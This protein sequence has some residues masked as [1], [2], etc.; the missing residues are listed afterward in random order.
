MGEVS[1]IISGY[2]LSGLLAELRAAD[3]VHLKAGDFEVTLGP[4]SFT[5]QQLES[6]DPKEDLGMPADPNDPSLEPTSPY[7]PPNTKTRHTKPKSKAPLSN[8]G[9]P[10]HD[11]GNL[12]NP[13][14]PVDFAADMPELPPIAGY[15]QP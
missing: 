6:L 10:V 1:D 13:E 11:P 4:K 12:L 9:E 2:N 8:D 15:A 3:V 7:I 5:P 14:N